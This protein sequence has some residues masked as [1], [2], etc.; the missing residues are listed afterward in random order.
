[1]EYLDRLGILNSD[2]IAA[3]TLWLTDNDIEIL[4]K[5]KV[6]CVHNINSNTKLSSGY[7]F[8]YNELR[9]AG[10]NVC[11][12]TDGCASSNNLDM[13]ETMKTSALFQKAWRN[14]PKALPLQE[15][16]ELATVNG[17]K[18]LGLDTGELEE[19]KI[20]DI[21]IVNTENS[22]FL[23]PG[24]FLS[25]FI[26]SAHSDC[27]EYMIANGKFVMRNRKVKDEAQIIA[28]AQEQLIKI[29]H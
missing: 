29:T 28:N 16:I 14:D 2:V 3:H 9:D 25:N 23:S 22:F 21:I 20:A 11:L 10:A 13:L 6:N 12:G 19:G 24:N 27:I 4:G 18:A 5:R 17:A 15:L 8:K 7:M 26:Y 1:M